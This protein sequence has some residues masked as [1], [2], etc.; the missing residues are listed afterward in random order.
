MTSP[1][2][3]LEPF[4]PFPSPSSS[5]DGAHPYNANDIPPKKSQEPPVPL[6]RQVTELGPAVEIPRS[7]RRGLLAQ[8][9]L[10]AEIENPKTYSRKLKWFITFIVAVA[11]ATAPMGSSIFFPSLSQVTKELHTKT[12]ITNLSIALYMLSMSIFPLWWSSFSERLGR[13]TI[14][15]ASFAL[16]VLF[17]CLCAISQSIAMLIVMRML[18][19]GASASVQ[20]VGA[21]TI[22]DLWEPR[23]RGRAMGIFYLG[24]LCGPLFAPI[25]G[26]LLADRWGWRSTMWFLA[27]YGALTLVFILFALPETLVVRKLV[28][29]E[30]TEADSLPTART[31]SRVSSRQVLGVTTRWLKTLKMIFLD[32]LKI[33]LY[34]R[35]IPVLL[36]VY[37]AS[38]AF[39][40]LYVLNVS[41][42]GTFG[43][44]PYN[45][46]TIII[47]LLYIPN[48]IGYVVASL[49]GGRWM[50]S[51]MQRE[52][53][54]ANRYDD[55]GR[56]VFRPED[57]MRENAL[58]GAFLYPAALIWYGW[59]V[60]K[61]TYWLVPMIANFF[62]GIGSMLIFSMVTTMLTEFMPKKSSE[63]VA[64]NNFVRNIFSCVGSLVTAP[65]IH[66]IGNG[67]LF[68]ILGLVG[69][70]SSSVIFLMRAFGPRWRDIMDARMG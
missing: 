70:A 45:F 64:L 65:V 60:D 58:L 4:P 53:K 28:L 69:F 46:S 9:T 54:K 35:F 27:G 50:D 31:L 18:S 66:G 29:P 8:V 7:K 37:Y 62:F 30:T 16:F 2:E 21:G 11:G 56:L 51:I 13:R 24:P 67:W 61:G 26:G 49:F 40:S 25:V 15:L 33:V 10:V 23:E 57:R 3:D 42:E 39:G 17:N 19:G 32:P 41:I 20:A 43:K 63:G 68:T 55:K 44:A 52:A 47:G 59:T 22:A 5:F 14:Y 6:T 12:T 38:I 36:S 48:S 34:L 1:D